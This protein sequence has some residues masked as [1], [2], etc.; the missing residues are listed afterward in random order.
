MAI[1]RF[2]NV[3]FLSKKEMQEECVSLRE[4]VFG[5]ADKKYIALIEKLYINQVRQELS[6]LRKAY[7]EV[8][9]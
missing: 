4:Q 8:Y 7:R 5:K 6:G 2:R 3:K 1:K 9:I